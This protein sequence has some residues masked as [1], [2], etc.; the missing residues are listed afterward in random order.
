MPTN[1]PPG[2]LRQDDFAGFLAASGNSLLVRRRRSRSIYLRPIVSAEDNRKTRLAQ[3]DARGFWFPVAPREYQVGAQ[4]RWQDQ[5]LVGG[6]IIAHPLGAPFREINFS[7]FLPD[8]RHRSFSQLERLCTSLR[9]W[10]DFRDPMFAV[11]MLE[12]LRD[13]NDVF[14]LIIGT[15]MKT[16]DTSDPFDVTETV[17]S[18]ILKIPARIMNFTWSEAAGRPGDI[19]FDISFLEFEQ[20]V[21]LQRSPNAARLTPLPATYTPKKGEDLQ[22]V[23][24][25][26][27]G[28]IKYWTAIYTA[29]Q[30]KW[31]KAGFGKVVAIP[32]D[33]QVKS[34]KS[35]T[36]GTPIAIKLPQIDVTKTQPPPTQRTNRAPGADT[37][38]VV[39]GVRRS[40]PPDTPPASVLR[41]ARSND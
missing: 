10:Q 4:A 23:A 20:P 34:G 15:D 9:N 33:K 37:L 28:N 17:S 27:F 41:N 16:E 22:D 39:G 31:K 35:A 5:E 18:N 12:R 11:W 3:M 2:W 6:N 19:L 36:G 7:S 32:T 21:G 30:D 1:D 14:W 13:T 40:Y 26:F 25:R 24:M 8:W 38:G 29:N